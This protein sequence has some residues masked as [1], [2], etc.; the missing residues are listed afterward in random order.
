MTRN[1][2]G[3]TLFFVNAF[4]CT[5]NDLDRF[6]YFKD[7][8]CVNYRCCLTNL[9]LNANKGV[10]WL[11]FFVDNCVSCYLACK[12][13]CVGQL[14]KTLDRR[15]QTFKFHTNPYGTWCHNGHCITQLKLP[16]RLW[17]LSK[18]TCDACFLC[19]GTHG[20]VLDGSKRAFTQ[21]FSTKYEKHCIFWPFVY[22]T[23]AFCVP[24]IA[25]FCKMG[26]KVQF[27]WK[28]HCYHLCVNYKD[29]C[30]T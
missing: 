8:F 1:R 21:V 30:L 20:K 13:K 2:N 11:I 9:K 16:F 12:I 28:W 6:F 14:L 27:S 25:K 19:R 22:T 26:F 17:A 15:T 10:V 24:E 7:L 23:K 3:D 29:A 18:G 5:E 4:T